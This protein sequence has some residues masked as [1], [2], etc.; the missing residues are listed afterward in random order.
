MEPRIGVRSVAQ[1]G[2]RSPAR[3]ASLPTGLTGR[4]SSAQRMTGTR[5]LPLYALLSQ[6]L[7]AFTVDYEERAADPVSIAAV[8]AQVARTG[9]APGR[10]WLERMDF[11]ERAAGQ[12]RADAP[13]RSGRAARAP[14]EDTVAAVTGR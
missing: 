2:P 4:R 9:V 1:R 3:P 13:D 10:P 7:M 11:I 8:L 6:A 12:R 14:Y 5:D